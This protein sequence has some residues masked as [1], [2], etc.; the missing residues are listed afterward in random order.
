MCWWWGRIATFGLV[1]AALNA[2]VCSVSIA[3]NAAAENNTALD[4]QSRPDPDQLI[5]DQ[6]R[7]LL[8]ATT[9]LWRHGGFSHGGLLWAPSG[10]DRDGPVLKLIFGGGIYR[11]ISGALGNT[12]VRGDQFAAAVLPGWRFV[13]SNLTVT[14]FLGLDVQHHRLTP[15][16]PS[17]GLRGSYIGPRAG[18]EAWY[19]P[20]P[21]T[22]VTADASVSTVGPSYST[23]LAAGWRLLDAFYLGPEVQA[24]GADG[25][26]RQLRAGLHI[27][28][29]R[30][31]NFEWSVGAG[32]ATDTDDKSGAYGKIGVFT[33]R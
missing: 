31:E 3:S 8:F 10:L 6:A 24:F 17:A 13:R 33:R 2:A 15:H 11:Y 14:L 18:F 26:Y 5:Q 20:T 22:M 23:R 25:N 7:V 19:Q 27:T 9:D 4:G 21:M 32:W 29:L 16:D 1:A 28:G 12:E 30:I